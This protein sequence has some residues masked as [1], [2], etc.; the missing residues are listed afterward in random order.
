MTKADHPA[1]A[2]ALVPGDLV[3]IDTGKGLAYLQITHD[4]ASYP[5][6]LRALAGLH[7]ARP[8]DLASLAAGETAFTAMVPLG[9][10]L[11]SGRLSGRR[12]G[13]F[14]LP[15]AARAFPTFRTPIRDRTGAVVYWWFWD[16]EG[17]RFDADPGPEADRFPLREVIGV[18]A[19]LER[20]RAPSAA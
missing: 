12:L 11:A 8:A 9:Q 19:L 2:A 14:A 4:H 6:V 17:L 7:A 10:M 3:E 1:T 15:D 18:D 16:G 5:E 13:Q 20:L